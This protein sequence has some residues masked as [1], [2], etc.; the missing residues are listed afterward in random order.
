M[1]ARTARCCA[2]RP[3]FLS[4][5]RGIASS[6]APRLAFD[7]G[8]SNKPHPRKKG[9]GED[10]YF[11]ARA[12]GRVAIGVG[13]GVGGAGDSGVYAAQLMAAAETL[14]R[15]ALPGGTAPAELLQSAWVAVAV[16]GRSTASLVELDGAASVLRAANLGDSGYWVLRRSE[17]GTLRIVHRSRS[18][19]H[20]FN[21][22]YQLGRLAGVEL[23]EPS[24]ASVSEV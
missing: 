19:Q 4:A 12:P 2:A 13:D 7:I 24:D 15:E 14:Y 18:Q 20:A 8:A 9:P 17:R 11:V 6:S 5:A 22:P 1:L 16:E 3:A 21:C 10:A 23:N